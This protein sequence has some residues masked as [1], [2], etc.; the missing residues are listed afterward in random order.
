MN[1]VDTSGWLHCLMNGPL[2]ERYLPYLSRPKEV[3]T[4]TVVMYEVYKKVRRE[5]GEELAHVAAGS[6]GETNIVPLTP[7]LAYL[8]ADVSLKHKLPMADAIIYATACEHDARLLT[9]DAD[10]KGFPG[11]TYFPPTE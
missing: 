4:P 11:V 5:G 8:A 6:M 1:L 2:V 7:E 10:L 3:L 9:S